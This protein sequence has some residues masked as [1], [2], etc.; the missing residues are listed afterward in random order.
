MISWKFYLF[1]KACSHFS[2]ENTETILVSQ[3]IQNYVGL[4]SS[5]RIRRSK[6]LAFVDHPTIS[7]ILTLGSCDMR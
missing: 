4:S 5:L 1:T 6:S 3:V 7:V 2:E